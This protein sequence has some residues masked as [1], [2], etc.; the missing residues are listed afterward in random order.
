MKDLLQ[1]KG[2]VLMFLAVILFNTLPIMLNAL[3]MSMRNDFLSN[4]DVGLISLVSSLICYG[5]FSIGIALFCENKNIVK[6]FG[7][8]IPILCGF[9]IRKGV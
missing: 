2:L 4:F 8:G 7:Y 5:L 6:G 1:R 9:L 3:V